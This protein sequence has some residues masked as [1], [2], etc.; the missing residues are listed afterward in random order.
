M[1]YRNLGKAG[2]K[3]SRL[4]LGTMMFGGA[5]NEKDSIEI[6]HRAMDDG[7][8]FIDTANVYNNGESEVI[9]GKALKGRRD[10]AVVATKV[11]GSRGDGP[12]DSGTGRVHIF[13][14][15]ENSLRR[16]DTDY[17]DVYILH[18]RDYTTPLEESIE[19]LNDLVRQGKVRYAGCSNFYGYE[20]TECLWIADRNNHAPMS[21]VQPLYN[22]VNRD[23]ELEL[24]PC[25]K[26]YGV[27]TMVYSPLARGVLAGKYLPGQPPPEGSR[28]DRQDPRMMVTETREESYEVAQQLKPL[29]DAHGKSMTQFSLNWVLA[30]PIVTSAIVGPRT[31]EH[32]EDNIGCL[33]W[34][35]EQ[36]A[37]DKIDELVPPGEHTGWGFNDPQYPVQGR[38]RP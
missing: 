1:E 5:T 18:S 14:E 15:V 16:L 2:V 30:N 8:N 34:E 37:L 9:L 19:A 33:G 27:G 10:R 6:I 12:N 21:A 17:I 36:D 32:Y 38:P 4:C 31:M 26:K 35:I 23:A 24:F 13:N 28:A 11:R 29:A 25:C 3:V 20:L 7:I 22:I